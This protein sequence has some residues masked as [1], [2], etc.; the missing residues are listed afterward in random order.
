MV[1]RL[2]RFLKAGAVALALSPSAV[3]AAQPG[4][5]AFGGFH[6]PANYLSRF[7]TTELLASN[8]VGFGVRYF[9]LPLS[10]DIRVTL[11]RQPQYWEYNVSTR[12]SETTFAVGVFN[13]GS[14][15]ASGIPRLEVTHDPFKGVQFS[16]LLQ[17]NTAYSRFTGGYAFTVAADRVRVLNN[18]GVAYDSQGDREVVAP[19]TQTQVGGGNGRSLGRL[20]TYFSST[21]RVFTFP[22]QRQAQGSIDLYAAANITPTTG[23]TFDGSHLERFA[24]GKVPVDDLNFAR[25]QE[26]N[27]SVTYRLPAAR[28]PPAFTLGAVRTRVTRDWTSDYTYLRNDVLFRVEAL[29]TLIGPS[30]G[31]QWSP[32]GTPN[33]WLISLSFLPK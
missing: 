12:L 7:S 28:T 2:P 5:P 26:S 13:N 21:A 19:Y 1:H 23:L 6:L 30:I 31:Y 27:F 3:A 22:V 11:A 18:V 9:P 10:Q 8:E 14:A 25:Y 24:V 29:P 20:N 33:R 32:E 4:P 15:A 16:G 17:G